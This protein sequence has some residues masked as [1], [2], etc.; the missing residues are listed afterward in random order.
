MTPQTTPFTDTLL[1]LTGALPTDMSHLGLNI[2]SIAQSN[3]AALIARTADHIR[4]W[5]FRHP[6]TIHSSSMLLKLADGI[7][8]LKVSPKS[9][10]EL[11]NFKI[12]VVLYCRNELGV[13]ESGTPADMRWSPRDAATAIR[14]T[15]QFFDVHI[16]RFAGIGA[17][18]DRSLPHVIDKAPNTRF[19]GTDLL[20]SIDRS[21][22]TDGMV[23]RRVTLFDLN[24]NVLGFT[25]TYAWDPLKSYGMAEDWDSVDTALFECLELFWDHTGLTPAI[26]S[27]TGHAC[28]VLPSLYIDNVVTTEL[29]AGKDHGLT[30]VEAAIA[31]YSQPNA[32]VFSVIHPRC[33][34]GQVTTRIRSRLESHAARLGFLS[35]KTG[36]YVQ[37]T[38]ATDRICR[39]I[40]PLL[41]PL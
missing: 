9:K 29:G 7:R 23:S 18:P 39:H 41:Q 19:A 5:P 21:P 17:A 2:R 14:E 12:N 30:L 3:Q 35:L 37:H 36:V 16:A 31:S 33:Q 27:L 4:D 20:L 8:R 40:A 26:R 1:A 22:P 15:T 25:Q 13:R 28:G 32:F 6:D 34:S 24:A 38:D 10:D 11:A